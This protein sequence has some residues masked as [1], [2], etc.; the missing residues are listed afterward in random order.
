M[1]GAQLTFLNPFGSIGLVANP[2]AKFGTHPNANGLA[3]TLWENLCYLK[4]YNRGVAQA[5]SIPSPGVPVVSVNHFD[6]PRVTVVKAPIPSGT[7]NVVLISKDGGDAHDIAQD[8]QM[9]EIAELPHRR[10]HTGV[11]IT[12]SKDQATYD[13][14]GSR[15]TLEEP[16]PGVG[17]TILLDAVGAPTPFLRDNA[18]NVVTLPWN[19]PSATHDWQGSNE[20]C[21]VCTQQ[22]G[23]GQPEGDEP[24]NPDAGVPPPESVSG[25]DIDLT[26]DSNFNCDAG[27]HCCARGI[28]VSCCGVTASRVNPATGNV[29]DEINGNSR[30]PHNGVYWSVGGGGDI[31]LLGAGGVSGGVIEEAVDNPGSLMDEANTG[32]AARY[33]IEHRFVQLRS[34][35]GSQ[36]MKTFIGPTPAQGIVRVPLSCPRTPTDLS[37]LAGYGM[38]A[39]AQWNDDDDWWYTEG[40]YLEVPL[41]FTE[42]I[43]MAGPSDRQ[44]TDAFLNGSRMVMRNRLRQSS[45][46]APRPATYADMMSAAKYAFAEAQTALDSG[47]PVGYQFAMARAN[48]YH[49]AAQALKPPPRA[50]TEDEIRTWEFMGG[51][52]PEGTYL[53]KSAG[54]GG[55][56][57]VPPTKAASAGGSEEHHSDPMY[58][59]GDRKQP[60]TTMFPYDHADLHR[61]MNQFLRQKYDARGNHMCPQRGNPGR[62]IRRNFSRNERLAAEA[63]FYREFGWKYPDAARDFFAQH[64]Q[65][66]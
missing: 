59:G 63:E 32:L 36:G 1:D 43:G 3:I 66:R 62:K 64:P 35:V 46:P 16:L 54:D 56:G 50:M 33:R 18:I 38:A 45:A 25:A 27:G 58:L 61:E 30:D 6:G 22:G 41:L 7:S 47:D 40:K 9:I 17:Q 65:L 20:L 13:S 12:Q 5:D 37:P 39:V 29:E 2:Q 49:S 57:K 34:G 4:S 11:V 28:D 23:G 31:Q 21:L 44:L 42:D 53:P 14:T 19:L 51:D 48:G 60:T 10:M 15:S 26:P 52:I 8:G 24:T 55:N